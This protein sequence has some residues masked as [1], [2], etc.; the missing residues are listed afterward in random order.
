MFLKISYPPH[1]ILSCAGSSTFGSASASSLLVDGLMDRRE[2]TV[3][4]GFSSSRRPYDSTDSSVLETLSA[5]D[6]A[7]HSPHASTQEVSASV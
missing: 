7:I 2:A 3:R 5:L 4:Y 6:R 1:P